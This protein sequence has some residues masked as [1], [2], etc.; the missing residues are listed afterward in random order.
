MGLNTLPHEP[1]F[2]LL[3]TG[4]RVPIACSIMGWWRSILRTDATGTL[5]SSPLI[6]DA[7]SPL[8]NNI[9]DYPPPPERPPGPY[10]LSLPAHALSIFLWS[11][12]R[13]LLALSL[14]ATISDGGH[15]SPTCTPSRLT[16]SLCLA[17]PNCLPDVPMIEGL[18]RPTCAA[19]ST[20]E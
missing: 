7:T 6:L 13:L 5:D 14:P 10:P 9:L 11:P 16:T 8:N 15:Q 20:W 12:L 2:L 17:A 19:D 3:L 1:L 18:P 4:L